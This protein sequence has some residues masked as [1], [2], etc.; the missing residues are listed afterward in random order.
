VKAV[1][2]KTVHTLEE[3][4]MAEQTDPAIDKQ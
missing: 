2:S 4:R 1:A 3:L